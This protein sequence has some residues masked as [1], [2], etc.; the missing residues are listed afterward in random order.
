[1][2]YCSNCVVL[3]KLLSSAKSSMTTGR[4]TPGSGRSAPEAS[5]GARR[6]DGRMSYRYIHTYIYIYIYIFIRICIYVYTYTQ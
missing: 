5:G 4:W 3:V 1:M 2:Y 6:V